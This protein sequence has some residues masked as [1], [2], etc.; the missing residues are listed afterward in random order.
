[1]KKKLVDFEKIKDD[2]TK[3]KPKY[4]KGGLVKS[5]VA[6]EFGEDRYKYIPPT[7]IDVVPDRMKVSQLQSAVKA[8]TDKVKE[9]RAIA[10]WRYTGFKVDIF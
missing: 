5:E 8:C 2:N 3:A 7:L 10:P 9:S 1:M 4:K 6:G